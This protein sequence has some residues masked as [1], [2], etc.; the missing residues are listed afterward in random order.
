M[1]CMGEIYCTRFSTLDSLHLYPSNPIA[2]GSPLNL[3]ETFDLGT[4]IILASLQKP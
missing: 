1:F 2:I 4:R 3:G